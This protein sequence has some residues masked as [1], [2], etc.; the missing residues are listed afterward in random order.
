MLQFHGGA[1][2]LEDLDVLIVL[3]E[4]FF[5]ELD[6]GHEFLVVFGLGVA[7]GV[8][9]I[10]LPELQS[11][12]FGTNLPLLIENTEYCPR[13]RRRCTR[14]LLPAWDSRESCRPELLVAYEGRPPGI[15]PDLG[16]EH[17]VLLVYCFLL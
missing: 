2:F 9:F 17:L 3:L 4:F 14:S 15:A 5:C 11:T 6:G 13:R 12:Q 1:E 8:I 10:K 16:P 7:F